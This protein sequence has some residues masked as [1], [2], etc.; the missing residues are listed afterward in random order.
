MSCQKLLTE[1]G[2]PIDAHA[3]LPLDAG[4]IGLI[5]EV[6]SGLPA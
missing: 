2:S 6:V 1:F 3:G 5:V 4:I